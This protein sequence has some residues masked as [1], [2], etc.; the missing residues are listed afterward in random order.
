MISIND[1]SVN[2][3]ALYYTN[4]KTVFLNR[5][6]TVFLSICVKLQNLVLNSLLSGELHMYK[7]ILI[8]FILM[9]PSKTSI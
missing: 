6:N 3:C 2:K 7:P 1:F 9:S 4:R 5:K 8:V